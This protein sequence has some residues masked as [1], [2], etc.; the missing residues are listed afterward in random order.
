MKSMVTGIERRKREGV[1][2]KQPSRLGNY[3][4]GKVN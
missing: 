2:H 1:M 3:K 4:D